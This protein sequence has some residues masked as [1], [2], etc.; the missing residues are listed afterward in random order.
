MSPFPFLE[1]P[2][3]QLTLWEPSGLICPS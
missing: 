3:A 2:L 1:F